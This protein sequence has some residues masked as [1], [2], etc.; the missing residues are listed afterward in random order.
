MTTKNRLLT[1]SLLGLLTGLTACGGGGSDSTGDTAAPS[2]QAPS[3]TTTTTGAKKDLPSDP[4]VRL[5]QIKGDVRA[6]TVMITTNGTQVIPK[7]LTSV[8]ESSNA[9]GSG[10]IMTGNGHIVTNAHVAVGQGIYT[11]SIEGR[12]RPVIA[13]LTAIAECEDLA[14][15]KLIDGAPYPALSWSSQSPHISMKIGVAGFP[16]DVSSTSDPTPYTFTEG[17]INTDV[18]FENNYWSSADIFYHSAMAYGGNSG[19]PVVELDTGTVVGIHY[20]GGTNR[21]MALSSTTSRTIVD[22]LLAG[23][24][25]LAIG[26]SGEMFYR[27]VNAS[28]QTLGYGLVSQKPQQAT[29]QSPVGVWVRGVAA[30]GKAKRAGVLPGDIITAVAGVPLNGN[31]QTMQTYCNAMRSNNPNAGRVVDLEIVRPKAGGVTCTGEVN[32]RAMGVKG[33][34]S[35]ACPE[36]ALSPNGSYQGQAGAADS[37]LNHDLVLQIRDGVITGNGN[38]SDATGTIQGTLAPSGAVVMKETIR[39]Q[40]QTYVADYT[41]QYNPAT[42][43]ITGRITFGNLSDNWS[44]GAR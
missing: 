7:D 16:G 13:E 4:V 32:G 39:F 34:P 31:D 33:A 44:V 26:F 15:L 22:K 10:F 1:L 43:V 20:A 40:G 37:K 24:D 42:R 41:G 11:V 23:Q 35:T 27:Y 21:H 36:T 12:S 3:N 2:P 6:S 38:W 17:T 8:T 18:L 25:V 5:T 14:V 30:G 9:R 29:G 28:N 19:G